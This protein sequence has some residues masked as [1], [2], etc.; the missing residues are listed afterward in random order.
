MKR[1][2]SKYCLIHLLFAFL[3]IY[4]YKEEILVCLEDTGEVFQ[5]VDHDISITFGV[6]GNIFHTPCILYI[7]NV[8]IGPFYVFQS[9]KT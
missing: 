6:L 7:Y 1:V 9:R 5:R 2:L 3:V 8:H 4:I